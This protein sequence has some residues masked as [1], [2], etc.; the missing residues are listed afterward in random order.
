MRSLAIA[1]AALA[2]TVPCCWAA[3]P[4]TAPSTDLIS[5]P[6][7]LKTIT[8][9]GGWAEPGSPGEELI[10]ASTGFNY[11]LLDDFSIGMEANGYRIIQED[12]NAW[13]GGADLLFRNHFIDRQKWSLYGELGLGFLE[14]DRRVPRRGTDFNFNVVAGPG[15]A[16]HLT[17]RIDLL[18][19]I[20]YFHVSNARAQGPDNN[21]SINDVQAYA[22][23]MFKI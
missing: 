2:L 6:A 1:T 20:R 19:S 10:S 9:D 5:Y 13:A 15:V 23:L 17:S 8:F 7:G 22:G 4:T 11:Y 12:G 3:D 14:A 21:P 16:W 18:T